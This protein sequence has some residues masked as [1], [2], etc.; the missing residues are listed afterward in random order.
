M[1]INIKK[2]IDP[3]FSLLPEGFSFVTISIFYLLLLI[4]LFFHQFSKILKE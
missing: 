1:A 4:Y 2:Y 3:F